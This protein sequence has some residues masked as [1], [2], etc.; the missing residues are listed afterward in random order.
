ML[1]STLTSLLAKGFATGAAALQLSCSS[2]DGARKSPPVAAVKEEQPRGA[3]QHGLAS[4]YTDHRTASG[5]RFSRHAM[6]AA[7]KHLPLGCR[8][9]VTTLRN[10]KTCIVR[11][12]DRGPYI[13]GRV[14]DLSRAAASAVGM[15]GSGIARVSMSIAGCS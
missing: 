11:I 3:P 9:K 13:R 7:H 15:T 2:P 10:G 14:I 8:C 5:E 1:M 6:A 12:N 4:I